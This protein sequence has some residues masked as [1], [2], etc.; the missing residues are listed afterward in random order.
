LA[1]APRLPK[2]PPTAARIG[3][4]R[5][6][7]T[8]NRRS[9]SGLGGS[10]ASTAASMLMDFFT[11]F[12]NLEFNNDQKSKLGMFGRALG[13]GASSGGAVDSTPLPTMEKPKR[14][15]KKS[16]PSFATIT[17]QLDDLVKSANKIGVYTKEQQEAILKQINQAKRVAKEQQLENKAPAVPELPE[18]G[19]GSDLGPL[20]TSV[21][22]LIKKID[23]LSETVDGLSNGG[24]GGAGPSMMPM[25]LSG[26][27]RR[28]RRA[29]QAR[30]VKSAS[31]PTG[32]RYAAGSGKGGQY[33]KAPSWLGRATAAISGGTRSAATRIAAP[34]AAGAASSRVAGLMTAGFRSTK[35]AGGSIKAAVRKAAGPIIGKALGR[36]ALKSIPLVGVGLGAAFAVSRLMQ[37]DV[38]GAGV[39]L[40]SGV[41]GPLTA[42]PALGASVARDTYASVY[43]VQPEQDPNFS[44]RY[45]ELKGEIDQMVKEQLSGAVKPASTPTDRETGETETPTARPQA[46]PVRQPPAVPAVTPP[47]GATGG[48][49]GADASPAASTTGG[50]GAGTTGTPSA[51]A[52][53]TTAGTAAPQQMTPEPT[54]GPALAGPTM[55]TNAMSGAT[56]TAQQ[57]PVSAEF[58]GYGYNPTSGK[59]M[60]QTGNTTRGAA[61]G[62]GNIPSPVYSSPNLD[63][64]FL[65]SLFFNS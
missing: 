4:L 55:E 43:G 40:G 1:K 20:D 3:Q 19:T 44:A 13:A 60:P 31:S 25:D 52:T 37:G 45:K 36:T 34:I 2:L 47:A 57:M 61:A 21:N 53:P 32:Y 7:V 62:V 63:E 46:A 8:R 5:K 15:S 28:G 24:L 42:V 6:R 59:F 18:T 23:E 12:F 10:A 48:D 17:T 64:S 11:G 9:S 27:G 58:R 54:T 35:R 56:L 22:A 51:A 14:V 29:P 26:G 39:E 49:A 16:N 38:V 65:S 41:A 33:A 50:G 30:V